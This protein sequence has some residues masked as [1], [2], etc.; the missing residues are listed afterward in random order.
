MSDGNGKG[1]SVPS[2][3]K[4]EVKATWTA[5][6]GVGQLEAYRIME[7]MVRR[8]GC[9]DMRDPSL[10]PNSRAVVSRVE[11]GESCPDLELE[12]LTIELRD[13]IAAAR[14]LQ[15][16]IDATERRVDKLATRVA[17]A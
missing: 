2:W 6:Q 15:H 13:V 7:R 12:A 1:I 14:A 17:G 5:M 10:A 3:I 4:E 9:G 8:L 16:R 11:T